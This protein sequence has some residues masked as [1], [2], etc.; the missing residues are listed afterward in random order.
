MFGGSLFHAKDDSVSN[1]QMRQA[2]QHRREA[3]ERD[4][5]GQGQGRGQDRTAARTR[6]MDIDITKPGTP[7]LTTSG[8]SDEDQHGGTSA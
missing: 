3:W 5:R 7:I 4:G 6:H 2:G 1:E 8:L